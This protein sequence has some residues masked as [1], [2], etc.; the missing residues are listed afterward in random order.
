MG[1]D[2]FPRPLR[3]EKTMQEGDPA[4]ALEFLAA[5]APLSKAKLKEA[6]DKGAVWLKRTGHARRRLRRVKTELRPGDTITLYYDEQVLAQPAPQAFCVADH[7]LYSVWFK[8]AGLLAQGTDYGDH[9]SLLRQV[10]TSK[11]PPRPSFPVHRLD[12]E[13]TGLMLVAHSSRAAA[14]LSRLFVKNKVDKEYRV[15]VLGNLATLGERGEFDA[16]LDGKT[17]LT[18]FEL[19]R[20]DPARNRSLARVQLL[21]GRQHQIRRHF[22]A[23]GYPVIGDPRYGRGNKD[24]G[25]LRLAAVA[26][27]FRCPFRK[28]PVRFELPPERWPF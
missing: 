25:G 27:A 2:S 21:T 15:E 5:F 9:A 1:V 24:P 14:A 13:A 23:A 22:A 19:L 10:E 6:M 17:A 11:H 3:L 4:T 8:P 18:R 12:R 16:P 28:E 20:Y 7:G 26:L